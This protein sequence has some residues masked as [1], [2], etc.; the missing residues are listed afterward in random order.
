M[1]SYEPCF[2]GWKEGHQPEP[3]RKP[4]PSQQNVWALDTK[5]LDVKGVH[6]TQKP[7]EVCRWPIRWHLREGE[8]CYEPFGGSGTCLIAAA[9]E[10][11]RCNAVEL[12]PAFCDVIRKRWG[13]Y[14]RSAGLDVGDGL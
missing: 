6:P 2:Y 5:S 12:S 3:D 4:P 11:R 9:M 8:L 1:W 10:G 13:G 7:L 14:A